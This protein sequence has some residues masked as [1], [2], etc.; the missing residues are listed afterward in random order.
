MAEPQFFYGGQA[1][2]EG[3]MIRGR[4][5]FGLAVRRTN[6]ELY[7]VCEPLSQLFTGRLRRVPVIRGV[8]VLLETL[9][10]GIKAL[11][12]SAMLAVEDQ[13]NGKEEMPR[14][15]M[16][17]TI[18]F[19]LALGIGLFFIL[20]LFTVRTFDDA[21]SSDIVSNLVEGILRLVLLIG[22]VV[23][24]GFMRDIRRVFAY[25]GAE[26]MTVHAHEAGLPLEVQNVRQFPAAHPRCGTAFLLTVMVVA[27][28]VFAFLGRP[29]LEWRILS[30]VLLIPFIAAFS[31]EVIRFSGAHSSSRWTRATSYPGLLLQR[32]TTRKP[33]DE[34][35]E[36]AIHAMKATLAAD[37][38]RLLVAQSTLPEESLPEELPGLDTAAGSPTTS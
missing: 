2:I 5:F 34:Q 32:L 20:P 33:D 28:L 18:A 30:R 36:V 16:G 35:I 27:I 9:T 31:Y 24:I 26:H 21:I 15:A 10:L 23:V 8:I 19:S 6:G 37:E 3:V 13:S 12:R 22:Y 11:N 29:P 25:H 38:G 17:V 14:W 7:S 1:V 4:R